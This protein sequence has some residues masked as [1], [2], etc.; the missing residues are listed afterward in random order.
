[1]TEGRG[2]DG[3]RRVTEG[4]FADLAAVTGLSEDEVRRRVTSG[5]LP[6]TGEQSAALDERNAL[7]EWQ[8]MCEAA[9]RRDFLTAL[10]RVSSGAVASTIIHLAAEYVLPDDEPRAVLSEHWTRA[11]SPADEI[12]EGSRCLPVLKRRATHCIDLAQDGQLP[13]LVVEPAVRYA[14]YTPSRVMKRLLIVACAILVMTSTA[15]GAARP[16]HAKKQAEANVLKALVAAA[17]TAQH[18]KGS[19]SF[20]VICR[21]VGYHRGVRY[22]TFLCRVTKPDGGKMVVRYLAVAGGHYKLAKL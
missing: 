1:M 19:F 11:D 9:E 8:H 5:G 7:R 16:L 3:I 14:S 10:S 21:G 15:A 20:R 12:E 13:V 18:V 4:Y 2:E 22:R 6:L 17:M